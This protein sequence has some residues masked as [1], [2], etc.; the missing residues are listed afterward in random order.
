[1]EALARSHLPM[2]EYAIAY[3]TSK[4]DR[5]PINPSDRYPILVTS[6]PCVQPVAVPVP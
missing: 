4:A 6:E 2:K 3:G 1:M 5:Q